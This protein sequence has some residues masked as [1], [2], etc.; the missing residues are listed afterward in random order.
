LKFIKWAVLITVLL[1]S[2]DTLEAQSKK[3]TFRDSIDNAFDISKFLLELHGFLPIIS[4]ITEP[5]VGYGAVGAAVF[6]IP[7]KEPQGKGFQ[8]P[9]I[10]GL[11]GGLTQNGTWLAGGGYFGFWKNNSIR[12]RGVLGYADIHLKYYGTGNGF[13]AENPASFSLKT[14]VIL[15]QFMFRIA[16]SNFWLG[17]SYVFSK[18]KVTLFEEN[19]ISWLDPFD[20]DLINSGV[21]LLT[22]YETYNN[23]L[24]PSKGVNIELNLRSYFEFLG[25]D[26]SSQKLTFSAIVFHPVMDRWVAG[27]RLESMLA[28][29]STPFFLKPYIYL[30]G[31]P[32]MRYQGNFTVLAETEQYVRVYKRWGLVG[33]AGYGRNIPDLESWDGGNHVWNA[34]GGFRYLLARQL[35]LQMGMD[36]GK[37]PEDWAFYI[38][39]GTAWLR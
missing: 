14:Y 4:P 29:E 8:M 11:A 31:V 21:T 24:S 7:K 2:I 15:Q 12:Y 37:G 36:V 18:T 22:Q 20:F 16:R 38:V 26:K 28:T 19:D 34:G 9:D 5:A 39:L 25:S 35:G 23:I 6:F 17:G 13:L 30:R 3:G 27:I 1:T 10:V 33:F 32:A